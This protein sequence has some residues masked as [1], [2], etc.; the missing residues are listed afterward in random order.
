MHV[1]VCPLAVCSPPAGSP[2][3]R[4]SVSSLLAGRWEGGTDVSR[5]A[6]ADLAAD[7][8]L[9]GCVGNV[10]RGQTHQLGPFV[11]LS[12]YGKDQSNSPV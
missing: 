3:S 7:F 11:V 10:E 8:N 9:F 1:T 5:I 2:S 12:T 6:A 4:P